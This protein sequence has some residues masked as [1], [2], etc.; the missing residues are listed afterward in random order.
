MTK[1]E[2]YLQHEFNSF[3]RNK[4]KA[5]YYLDDEHTEFSRGVI[6]AAIVSIIAFF[7]IY[8]IALCMAVAVVAG[9]LWIVRQVG[10]W[11]LIVPFGILIYWCWIIW[12]DFIDVNTPG[13]AD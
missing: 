5:S 10:A 4:K 11:S 13:S 1:R 8:I 12:K 3:L 7:I 2:E 6:I 9:I